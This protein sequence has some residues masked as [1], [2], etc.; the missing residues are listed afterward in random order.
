M[1]K[2]LVLLFPALF[3]FA[4]C[5]TTRTTTVQVYPPRPTFDASSMAFKPVQVHAEWETEIPH[6]PWTG[7]SRI[8]IIMWPDHMQIYTDS[9]AVRCDRMGGELIYTPNADQYVCEGVDAK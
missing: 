8:D 2:L 1:R 4:A 6:T 3:L 5:D 7:F 9:A